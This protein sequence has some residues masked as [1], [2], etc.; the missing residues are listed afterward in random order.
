MTQEDYRAFDLADYVNVDDD[1]DA[2]GV[3]IR[4]G[5]TLLHGLPF[6]FAEANGN[7]RAVK[8]EAGASAVL[9]L[10]P[11]DREARTLTFAHRSRDNL[12]WVDR[13]VGRETATYVFTY[14]NGHVLRVPLR[15]GFE[16][17][18]P[19][20][21]EVYHSRAVL[22]SLAV[23]DQ[24]D[25]LPDRDNGPFRLAGLRQTEVVGAGR[26]A[27]HCA[28]VG[29]GWRYWLWTWENPDPDN[30][31]T[32]IRI[33]TTNG[34][35]ELGGLCLGFADEHPLRPDRERAVVADVPAGYGGE[36]SELVISV[37]RGTSSYTTPLLA[38]PAPDDPF[39]AWGD[40]AGSTVVGAYARV[41]SV[42]SGTVRLSAN[43]QTLSQAKWG[44]LQHEK[45][46]DTGLRI[47][48]LGRNWV[49]TQI[50]DD[51]NGTP[52]PCRVHFSTPDGVP[53]QPHGHHQHV[54]SD[55]SSWNIDVGADVRL[56][57]TTY[58]YVDG[59][60][61]VWLPRGKVR[62]RAA[63]GFEYEPLDTT[64]TVDHET[65]ELT[66]RLKRRFD[67]NK[68]RWYS[69]DTHVHFASSFGALKEASA[70]GVSV[71]HLLQTQWGSHF[72]NIEDFLGRPVSSDDGSTILFTSQENRQHFL[73]HLSLLGLTEPVM[74]WSTDGPNEAVMGGSLETTLS[75][76][77]DRCR[78]Q[79]GTVVLPHF[80]VPLGEQAALIAT[81]RIDAIE[82]VATDSDPGFAHYYRYL[83]AGYRVPIVGGTD[84][85]SNDVPIGLSR[86]YV[87]IDANDDFG[88]ESW[89][90]ALKAGR[91]Y[92]TSG[93]I[94]DF[95]VNGAAIG[96]TLRLPERGDQVTVQARA[97]SILPMYQL[98]IVHSGH[99]VASTEKESGSFELELE[100]DID[101]NSPGWMAA[102][103]GGG[104][105]EHLTRH[106]DEWKRSIM[107]H[108]SPIYLAC[109]DRESAADK[110]ALE[111]IGAQ[112]ERARSYVL[113]RHGT[114]TEPDV[115]HHHGGDHRE[116]LVRPFDQARRDVERRLGMHAS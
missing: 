68:D 47:T 70:E 65:R 66:F 107:A 31:L 95:Y 7:A 90:N 30:P 5:L 51:A 74:P 69:G 39:S 77:A 1:V 100:V 113:H 27:D 15:E 109:G 72:S 18:M 8:V 10:A 62:V 75:D 32:E 105:P 52:I 63:R 106:R 93:P 71:V 101:V 38:Q 21:G 88:Y 60:C 97:R 96:D 3:A 2:P 91:S 35:L 116:F 9:T 11:A 79:G 55:L 80:S 82:S 43:T 59:R 103:V 41:S 98:E 37:D 61:E 26:W 64:I 17:G 42:A 19:W 4:R 25:T 81:N 56:G 45:Q 108:S 14:K 78:A 28:S 94:L 102:R 22:P 48:E 16:I 33:E 53:Y 13:P 86:T 84:K 67:L 50:V 24:N 104:G 36:G 92:M 12:T 111:H 40:G 34:A 54:N 49:R 85:M 115:L 44:E 87:R 76:W 6:N 20:L 89:C 29:G 73:G 114:S 112:V 110:E 58:A 46:P 99:V 23:P 83:S 57:R